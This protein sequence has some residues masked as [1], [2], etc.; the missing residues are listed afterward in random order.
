MS[1]TFLLLHVFFAAVKSDT[2]AVREPIYRQ[3]WYYF[4]AQGAVDALLPKVMQHH[5]DFM[6]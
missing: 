6:A 1:P 5:Y 3:N 2:I 4:R